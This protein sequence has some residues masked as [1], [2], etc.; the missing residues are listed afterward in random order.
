[1]QEGV[2]RVL[3]FGRFFS[4]NFGGLERHVDLLIRSMA[5]HAT[6]DN[7]VA[8]ESFSSATL[9]L[10]CCRVIKAPSLGLLAGTALCPT[11]PLVASPLVRYSRRIVL[12]STLIW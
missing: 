2:L 1:M 7:L 6:C 10:G 9:N 12:P 3:H 4:E 8:N 11:M 5:G